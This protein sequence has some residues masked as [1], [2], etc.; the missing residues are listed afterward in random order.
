MRCITLFIISSLI[1]FSCVPKE[2]VT[3][4]K[5]TNVQVEAGTNGDPML[6]G[7]AVFFNPNHVRVKLKE[8]KVEV[9]VDGKK[10]ADA[11]QKFDVIVPANAEFTVP[12]EIH[13]S[14]PKQGLL[15]TMLDFLGGKKYEVHYLGF[16]RIRVHGLSV[17]V[18]VDYKDEIKLKI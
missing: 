6:R 11:D 2:Q 9:F 1:L 5:I 18:P 10:S 3:L 17:K 15:N 13:L 8:I 12:L 16:V 7:D 4:R 14:L